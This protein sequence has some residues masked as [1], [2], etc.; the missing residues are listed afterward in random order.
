MLVSGVRVLF[1]MATQPDRFEAMLVRVHSDPRF[2]DTVMRNTR[3]GRRGYAVLGA[4]ARVTHR[5]Y[6]LGR[7]IAG[8]LPWLAASGRMLLG[9]TAGSRRAL[10]R[11]IRIRLISPL[12]FLRLIPGAVL[13]LGTIT[14]LEG[15]DT[16]PLRILLNGVPAEVFWFPGGAIAE[17]NILDRGHASAGFNAV[18]QMTG[19]M[20]VARVEIQIEPGRWQTVHRTLLVDK[21]WLDRPSLRPA[22]VYDADQW[23]SI[24][25]RHHTAQAGEIRAHIN[26]MELRPKFLVVIDARERQAGLDRTLQSLKAQVYPHLRVLLLGGPR[27]ID[28]AGVEVHRADSLSLGGAEP[29]GDY[30][31]LVAPGDRVAPVALYAFAAALNHDPRLEMIY[32]DEVCVSERG[33]APLR[34]PGWSADQLECDNYVGHSAVYALA[35]ARSLQ[36]DLAS[37]YDFT[38]RFSE[39]LDDVKI[40]HLDELLIE[41]SI[42]DPGEAGERSDIAAIQGRLTRTG[43]RGE[44]V[45]T[46]GTRHYHSRI[47]VPVPPLISIIVPL[48]GPQG[49]IPRPSPVYLAQRILA[50]SSYPKLEIILVDD[51]EAAAGEAD[52]LAGF[53]ARLL[54]FDR[55]SLDALANVAAAKMNAG[56]TAARGELLMFLSDAIQ[57]TQRDWLE[58]LCDQIAKPAVGAVGCRLLNPDQTTRHVGII[59]QQGLPCYVQAGYAAG[60]AES[61]NDS[62][63]VRN[64]LAVSSACMLTRAKL[65]GRVDGFSEAVAPLYSETDFCLKLREIGQ[66]IVYTGAVSLTIGDAAD[67]SLAFDFA[68]SQYYL[69]R[70][71]VRQPSDPFYNE[72]HLSLAPPTFEPQ[73]NDRIL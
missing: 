62:G 70:W 44:T 20:A 63:G 22:R 42:D 45:R 9:E 25:E 69:S 11:G 71:T 73:T 55:D 51:R 52:A 57:I 54:A 21:P 1:W 16:P 39:T 4:V 7:R 5:S 24:A 14:R 32:S 12:G 37:Q 23:V 29:A 58:R 18:L 41:R 33:A 13:Y 53:G 64:Y 59:Q 35:R 36:L 56:A 46:V 50:A 43:R 6:R 10:A 2:R 61:L 67:E 34:K 28:L 47:D 3:L 65:F 72:R 15:G 31:L 19:W 48:G 38:L 49:S 30:V 17:A 40:R 27:G 66:R 60:D 68:D 8:A 26:V